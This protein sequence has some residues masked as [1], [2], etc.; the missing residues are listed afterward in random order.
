MRRVMLALLAGCA[1]AAAAASDEPVRGGHLVLNG[2]GSKPAEVME[3]FIELAGG[4]EA[5]IVVFPT[6]SEESDTGD[7]Y[8]GV[9]EGYGCSNVWVAEIHDRETA[10][11]GNLAARVEAADGIWFSGGDQRR[12]TRA[13]DRDSG[14]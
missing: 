1:V 12:I 8:Q 14:R 11:E 2:G 10:L 6:A 7:Y 4:I 3:K 5:D 9:F 13:L